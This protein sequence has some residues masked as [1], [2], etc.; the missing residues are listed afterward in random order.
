MAPT[1]RPWLMRLYPLSWRNRYGAEFDALLE[2]CLHSPLD[3]LDVILGALDAHLQLLNGENINWRLLN[4]LNKL[5]TTILMVF[6]SYVAFIVAGM[7][8]VG[9]L[10]DSPMIPLMQTDPAPAFVMGVIRITAVLALL[11]VIIGGMPLAVTVIRHVLASDR[12]SIKLLL[13]P[14]LSFA[15]LMLYFGFV[16]LVG[17]GQIQIPGVAQVV[18]PNNFPLGNRLLLAG[19]MLL[20]VLGAVASTWAVWKVISRTD[21]ERASFRPAGRIVNINLYK[22]AYIPAVITTVSMSVMAVATIIWSKMVFSAL[23]QVFWGN[24]GL[25][26]T[27]TQPWVYGIIAVMILSSVMAFLG[28]AHGRSALART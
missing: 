20:F 2:E 11:A 22:F 18:Q 23:P 7:S 27:S 10:D 12:T 17:T 8:L 28:V 19:L 3:V 1:I 14:V 9:L 25:W 26:Q 4:M 21:I 24:F 6:A 15:I 13:V 16:F 5:R